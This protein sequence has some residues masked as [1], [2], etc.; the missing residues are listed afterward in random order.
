MRVYCRH[1]RRAEASS[2]L[3]L[4]TGPALVLQK[5]TS[6]RIGIYVSSSCS[7][8]TQGVDGHDSSS[9]FFTIVKPWFL[10]GQGTIHSADNLPN[11]TPCPLSVAL[12][13][14]VKF[15]LLHPQHPKPR[16]RVMCVSTLAKVCSNNAIPIHVNGTFS[17]FH[18]S[19]SFRSFSFRNSSLSSIHA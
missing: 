5:R 14:P 17:A 7:C 12:H 11:R 13:S 15:H 18:S 8:H 6:V 9:F 19:S 10:N 16:F 3:C 2:A 1:A 4:S